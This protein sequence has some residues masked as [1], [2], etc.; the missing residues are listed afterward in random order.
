LK[1]LFSQFGPILNVVMKGRY[2]FVE[3]EEAKDAEV[4]I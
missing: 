4:A 1:D 3:F 2:A